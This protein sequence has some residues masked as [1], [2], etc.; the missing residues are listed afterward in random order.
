MAHTRSYSSSML[1]KHSCKLCFNWFLPLL[2][3]GWS[4]WSFAS[5][6]F[7]KDSFN[8]GSSFFPLRR[9]LLV[10]G[11]SVSYSYVY[12]QFFY[13]LILTCTISFRFLAYFHSVFVL[14]LH[15]L[16]TPI[17]GMRR[18]F[19]WYAYLLFILQLLVHS[20]RYLWYDF[21]KFLVYIPLY[22]SPGNCNA[23]IYLQVL[24]SA[25]GQCARE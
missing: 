21:H 20:T 24:Y 23:A 6:L 13:S 3:L 9:S 15:Q 2:R 19:Q 1:W 22:L 7:V 5:F 8:F 17:K 12:I 10:V 14:F 16:S 25:V 18:V 4:R 11:L